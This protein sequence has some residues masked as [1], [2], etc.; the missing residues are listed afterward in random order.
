MKT[1]NN[2]ETKDEPWGAPLFMSLKSSVSLKQNTLK[3]KL[4]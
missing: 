2:K 1:E 3:S 4:N